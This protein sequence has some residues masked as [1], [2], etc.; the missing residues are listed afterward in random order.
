MTLRDLKTRFIVLTDDR[1]SHRTTRSID[2]ADGIRFHC[3]KCFETTGHEL[4]CWR[5]RVPQT[6]DPKPGRWEFKGSSLDDLSLV[7]GSSSVHVTGGC[8]AHFF[9]RGGRIEFA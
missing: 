9:V 1:G 6:I 4:I 8:Q 3:P 2:K 5:P 7:A